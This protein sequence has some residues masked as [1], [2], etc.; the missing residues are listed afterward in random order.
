M[1]GTNF[2]KNIYLA[3][4]MLIVFSPNIYYSIISQEIVSPSRKIAFIVF[5]IGLHLIPVVLFARRIKWFL[6][7]FIP[8]AVLSPLDMFFIYL[9]KYPPTNSALRDVLET[10]TSEAAEFI[11][12]FRVPAALTLAAVVVFAAVF[13]Y[14]LKRM[15]SAV[16]TKG[17]AALSLIFIAVTLATFFTQQHGDENK[18]VAKAEVF[19]TRIGKAYPIGVITHLTRFYLERRQLAKH[20]MAVE[21]FQYKLKRPQDMSEREIFILIIGEASRAGNYSI[22][23]YSRTTT[24]NLSATS[25]LISFP[26]VCAPATVTRMSLPVMLTGTSPADYSSAY[27]KP[28]VITFFKK[29]GFETHWISNQI[30]MGIYDKS[31]KSVFTEEAD[32]VTVLNSAKGDVRDNNI[33]YDEQI[34]PP[35][36]KFIA[37][38]KSNKLFFVLHTI[39]N[40][41]RYDYR[42]PNEF[43]VFKP[44][45]KGRDDIRIND[46]FVRDLKIN[47]YD[48]SVLY[49]D[50]FISDVIKYIASL[51]V[52]AA[53][54]FQADHGEDI[55]DDGG[56]LFGHGNKVVTK[57]V[58]HIPLIVWV[59]DAYM[60][61][62]PDKTAALSSNKDAKL[63]NGFLFHS[64]LDM[65]DISYEDSDLTKSVFSGKLKLNARG[66]INPSFKVVDCDK[67]LN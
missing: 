20:R 61:S 52:P 15:N 6:A 56:S 9:Y 5:S 24:P 62:H 28:G 47:S 7:L 64:L 17:A 33:K 16:N 29:A 42:Y 50:R 30:E 4:A 18:Y 43:D 32:D 66:I 40:H 23:G 37:E 55:F 41:Y 19:E 39:G 63:G 1:K 34:I 10:N 2:R 8:F 21:N 51:D 45:M 44:S 14:C 38:S 27:E 60:N 35:L 31:V 3:I 59:S 65:A 67:L 48:N 58:A 36:K 46:A 57:Y 25:N 22:N 54:V 12:G 49:V 11:Q 53:I 26:N 13:I